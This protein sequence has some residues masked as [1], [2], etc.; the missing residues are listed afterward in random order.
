MRRILGRAVLIA[1]ILP[2]IGWV[3][4]HAFLI[5]AALDLPRD[6]MAAGLHG[7]P[8]CAADGHAISEFTPGIPP[9]VRSAFIAAEDEGFDERPAAAPLSL[10]ASLALRHP[11]SRISPFTLGVVRCLIQSEGR[12]GQT[13][14]W[15]VKG[16]ALA[17]T[18]EEVMPKE[19]ILDN[20][21]EAAVL[22]RG[23][24]GVGSASLAYFDK[25]PAAL[26]VAEGAYLAGLAKA[27]DWYADDD[28]RGLERRNLVL[29][30]MQGAG[31]ITPAQYDS[32]VAEPL[33]RLPGGR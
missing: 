2:C 11:A 31:M 9:Y 20:Y 10:L 29:A 26:T 7:K 17:V 15:H 4:L 12:G 14:A 8:V 21:L 22:G 1:A 33:R 27:P 28:A 3:G 13:L 5:W 32:A 23:I 25:S 19:R 16:A 30:R 18:V 6:W 24:R